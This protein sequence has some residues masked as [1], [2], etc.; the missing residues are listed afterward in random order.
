MRGRDGESKERE[1]ERLEKDEERRGKDTKREGERES[2][3]DMFE[4]CLKL[5]AQFEMNWR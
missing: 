3:R 5:E 1:M 2:E 4:S